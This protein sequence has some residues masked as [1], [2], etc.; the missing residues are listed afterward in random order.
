MD[1]KPVDAGYLERVRSSLSRYGPDGSDLYK[2]E[3]I[4]VLHCAFHTTKES[5]QEVQPCLLRSGDV[6][7]W[8]GRLD[9]RDGLIRELTGL[10]TTRATDL[11]IVAA[12]YERWGTDCFRKL[13]GDWAI[14]IWSHRTCRVILAKDF[15]GTRQLYYC[16]DENQITWSTTLELLVLLAGKTFPLNE[17]YIAGWLSFYPATHLTPYV[18]IHS[19]PASSMVILGPQPQKHMTTQYW[20]FDPSRTISYRTDAEYE[21]HFRTVFREAVRCRLRADLPITAELS[22][23]MDSCSIVCMADALLAA[24]SAETPRLDTLSYYSDAEPNWNELPYITCVEAK[25]GRPGSHIN[26]GSRKM[27]SF[28]LQKTDFDVTPAC[29]RNQDAAA[30]MLTCNRVVLSG[31]GGDEVM[32]GVPTPVPELLDLLAR[33]QLRELGHQLKLWALDKRIPWFHLLAEAL[34]EALPRPIVGVPK[35]R[36]PAPWLNQGFLKRNRRAFRGYENRLRILGS[37]PSFQMNISTL[38]QLRRQLACNASDSAAQYEKRYP[39]LDRNLLEFAYSIP[40][41]QLV[42]P[43]RR[44]SLMRRALVGIVPT[45][46]IERKRKAFVNRTP[47]VAIASEWPSLSQLCHNMNTAQF[48]FVDQQRFLTALET[49]RM[50]GEIPVLRLMRTVLTEAWLISLRKHIVG[51]PISV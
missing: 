50:S 11:D 26:I 4:A 29:V 47:I 30:A 15:M 48:G 32:G 8:D 22:G 46:I 36:L 6:I 37:R 42:R 7:C 35:Q 23:G 39:Y 43:G 34:R 44:R 16:L 31:I 17:E 12:A 24:G 21:E 38:N 3:N 18:G 27:F 41:S 51:Y 5:R 28:D 2:N 13:V 20:D 33:G 9:N 10:L 14:A 49:A 1:G 19:V 25:R 40:R 45:E